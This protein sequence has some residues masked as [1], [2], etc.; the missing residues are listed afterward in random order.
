MVNDNDVNTTDRTHTV[1]IDTGTHNYII[2]NYEYMNI[3]FN[4][5]AYE[6]SFSSFSSSD[7][8][9]YHVILSN[10]SADTGIYPFYLHS[11]I[12]ASFHYLFFFLVVILIY[13]HI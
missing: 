3:I 8:S 1:Y 7:I 13:L 11:N 5:T 6:S 10:I 2:I 4:L 12:S 9:T